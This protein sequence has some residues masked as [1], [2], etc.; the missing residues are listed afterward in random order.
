VRKAVN[1]WARKRL[2]AAFVG[3]VNVVTGNR[4]SLRE[5]PLA[6]HGPWCTNFHNLPDDEA[7]YQARC[8]PDADAPNRLSLDTQGA[9]SGPPQ[10]GKTREAFACTTAG[11]ATWLAPETQKVSSGAA[12][13]G[14]VRIGRLTGYVVTRP[15]PDS[16]VGS[17]L[18]SMAGALWLARQLGRT[19]IVDWRGQAQLP[20]KSLN[21]FSEFFRKPSEI[22]GVPVLYAPSAV[23]D[24]GP[25]SPQAAWVTPEEAHRLAVGAV[26]AETQFVV[27]QTYHGVDRVH[28]G[29][30]P[31][32]YRFLRE[33]Y[34]AIQPGPEVRRSADDWWARNLGGAF[35]VGVNVRTGN[36]HYYGKNMPYAGRV[37]ISLFDDQQ[38][39]LRRVEAACRAR[40]RGLP[41]HLREDFAIFYATDSPSMSALL[42]KLPSARTRRTVFPPPGSGDLFSFEQNPETGRASVID[43]LADMFLLA[44]CDALVFNSSMFNQYARVLTGFFGGNL[45]HLESL[46]LLKTTERRIATL[47]RRIR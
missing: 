41:K 23:A 27:C 33:F 12:H 7:C 1:E 13:H 39:F 46:F 8:P 36:G 31:A 30:E 22:L 14:R 40:V 11:G 10:E 20:D 42:G 6:R 3:G 18:S 19:L 29:P 16:N 26:R 4:S 17:N 15:Y 38:R 25:G 45:V 28:A 35:V 44:R 21:Y 34:R 9:G 24:Y 32:R 5:R 37:D 2:D 47:R 43:T